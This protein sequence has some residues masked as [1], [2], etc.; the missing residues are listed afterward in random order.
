MNLSKTAAL[1]I[2]ALA[3]MSATAQQNSPSNE[4]QMVKNEAKQY[5]KTLESFKAEKDTSSIRISWMFSDSVEKPKQFQLQNPNR[6]V[7]DWSDVGMITAQRNGTWDPKS[8][9]SIQHFLSNNRMRAV[10]DSGDYKEVEF[11]SEGKILTAILKKAENKDGGI[12]GPFKNISQAKSMITPEMAK[13]SDSKF[14]D[15]KQTK[16]ASVGL[17]DLQFSHQSSGADRF[18]FSMDAVQTSNDVKVD[19]GK[20][21]VRLNGVKS[22]DDL[23]K[24]TDVKLKS[25][26][27]Q[28]FDVKNIGNSV[29]VKISVKGGFEHFAYQSGKDLV[30]EVRPIKEV[31]LSNTTG[32]KV[33][34]G[35]KMG[36]NFQ[37]LDIRAAL[38]LLADYS[39]QNIV[40]SDAVQ[41]TVALR[42]KDVPWDQALDLILESKNLGMVQRGNVIWVAP[43]QE[44]SSKEQAKAEREIIKNDQ[45]QLRTVSYQLNYQKAEQVK[46]LLVD[47][48]QRI[49]SKKGAVSYDARTNIL[50][51]N[52]TD[53]KL[54]E[55]SNL[56]KKIDIAV[57]QVSIEAR[58]VEAN[59]D[60]A[61][62][63]G[64]KVGFNNSEQA[65]AKNNRAGTF[66]APGLSNFPAS[67]INGATPGSFSFMLFNTALTSVLNME[68]SALVSDGN[69]RIVSSPRVVTADQMEATI[70][71]GTEIPYQKAT[72]S[73]ATSVEFKKAVMSLVVKPQIT[74]DGR[75]ILDLKVNK[76]SVGVTTLSGPAID[77]KKVTTQVLVENGGT[78]AIGGIIAEEEHGTVSKVPFL[79]DI[80]I[81]G[82]LFKKTSRSSTRKELM[83]LITP[84]IV[85]ESGEIAK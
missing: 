76:D 71:Q 65:F 53:S 24:V 85:T 43:Q 29:V 75:V 74:P 73:G 39:G 9:Q 28:N 70:E 82:N 8:P 30:V 32:D 78:V 11:V 81:I 69:G 48:D 18:V 51:V 47:K 14:E 20:L 19:N 21:V 31:V 66:N 62:E 57:R 58:I 15:K 52:D 60:F 68:L 40:V 67:A 37:S 6:T 79:G 22:A 35:A 42:L 27:V 34:K 55:V 84:K 7:F 25:N 49:L 63:L 83:I 64:A 59:E 46:N 13:I 26:L 5:A 38:Q 23:N 2:V 50:F 10:V 12:A 80:P 54:E 17:T 1:V 4:V 44:I 72:S 77:T 33:F 36:M 3:S 41:G 16:D 56:I 45:Q 61:K